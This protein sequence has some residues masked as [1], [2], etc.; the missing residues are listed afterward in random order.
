M[1]I[2][3]R[4]LRELSFG[5]LM[6]VYCE[7]NLENGSELW[8]DEP[9][10]RQIALAE[11]EFYNYLQE[12]FFR[13]VDV[14]YL[15]WEEKGRYVSALRLE[16]Y[17]DGLLLEG[18]ETMPEFRRK[19]YAAQLVQAATESVG[20]VKIYSHVGKH[21]AVSLR[22]H[23]KCGFEKILDYAVYADGSVDDRCVTLCHM[24]TTE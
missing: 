15:I 3:A 14:Q 17:R 6:D 10:G 4:S 5:K 2:I 16:P 12:V 23:E 11:Q 24:S 21:N 13:T 9:Q 19:G 7:G 22:T 1:L 20:A 18:L 8:P